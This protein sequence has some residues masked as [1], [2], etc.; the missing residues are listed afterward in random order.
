MSAN[1][2]ITRYSE[3]VGILGKHQ[4]GFRKGRS[5]TLAVIS[6]LIKWQ[7]AK[8][9]GKFTGCLLYDLSAAYDLI[10]MGL[11]M[12]KVKRYGFNKA[13]RE[14]LTSFMTGRTQAVKV[15]N[16]IS[17]YRDLMCCNPQG[18]PLACVLF[19][20]FVQDLPAWLSSGQIQGCA[21]DTVHFLEG[22]N[23]QDVIRQLEEGA[24]EI[25]S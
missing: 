4:H 19:L 20:I 24:G 11:L 21:D 16:Y 2:Q 17:E 18:S 6:S 25:L 1:I 5:T 13:S 3:R 9:R 7:D 22:D 8:E 23:P 10:S 15:G 12:E 14:W